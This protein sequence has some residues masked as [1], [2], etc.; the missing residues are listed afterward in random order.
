MILDVWLEHDCLKNLV[1]H[2]CFT[3]YVSNLE[4]A[5]GSVSKSNLKVERAAFASRDL[6]QHNHAELQQSINNFVHDWHGMKAALPSDLC[7]TW[8]WLN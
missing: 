1:H 8:K 2:M 6:H 7:P 5:D 4:L 3:S